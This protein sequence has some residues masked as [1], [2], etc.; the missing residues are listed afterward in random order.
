MR[1]MQYL[2][3]DLFCLWCV[4]HRSDLVL[5][6]I[7]S[8]VLEIHQWKASAYRFPSSSEI[9]FTEHLK[10]L[11]DAV[12]KNFPCLQKHW[13]LIAENTDV[14]KKEKILLK[15]FCGYGECMHIDNIK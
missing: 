7:E 1:M 10:N 14:L 5:S 11:A 13:G 15:D 6:D 8:S 9:R 2:G 4:A 3:K 12:W